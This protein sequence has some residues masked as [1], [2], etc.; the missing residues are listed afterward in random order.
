MTGIP[1][2]DLFVFGIFIEEALSLLLLDN[3]REKIAKTN[4]SELL[5][6]LSYWFLSFST[7]DLGQNPKIQTQKAK[8]RIKKKESQDNSVF[9][10]SFGFLGLFLRVLSDSHPAQHKNLEDFVAELC[11]CGFMAN[12]KMYLTKVSI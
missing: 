3:P 6:H 10:G 11:S 5:N 1:I 2:S 8:L 9:P 7:F 12:E 4:K